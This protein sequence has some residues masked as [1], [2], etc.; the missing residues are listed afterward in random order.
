MDSNSAPAIR[1]TARQCRSRICL[2]RRSGIQRAE[3]NPR[4]DMGQPV[5]TQ[6]T[7]GFPAPD[8]PFLGAA[9]PEPMNSNGRPN[10]THLLAL[11]AA[12]KRPQM[13]DG[14]RFTGGTG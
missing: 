1:Q 9:K 4:L 12:A 13:M 14:S 5:Q 7:M 11:F 6:V 10:L 2:D 8:D 3:G